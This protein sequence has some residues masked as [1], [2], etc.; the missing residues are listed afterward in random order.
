MVTETN[1]NQ[2]ASHLSYMSITLIK[3][4]LHLCL[5]MCT[6]LLFWYKFDFHRSGTLAIMWVMGS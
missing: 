2:A 6:E 1:I 3:L 5:T 4:E